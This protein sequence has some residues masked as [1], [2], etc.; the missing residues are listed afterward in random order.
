M[1]DMADLL[2]YG[3]PFSERED[4]YR[5]PSPRFRRPRPKG[6]RYCKA[7]PLRWQ[8]IED[9]WRLVDPKGEAHV[10]DEYHAARLSG[11]TQEQ[12]A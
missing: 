8:Q 6:C 3:D 7:Y 5:D 11:A 1:G 12:T 2:H 9:G 10:C 4:G